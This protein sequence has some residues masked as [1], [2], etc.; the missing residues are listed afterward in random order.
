MIVWSIGL[1]INCKTCKDKSPGASYCDEDDMEYVKCEDVE[2]IGKVDG[3]FLSRSGDLFSGKCYNSEAYGEKCDDYGWGDVS[4]FTLKVAFN[5][6]IQCIFSTRLSTV[7]AKET[8]VPMTSVIKTIV[9]NLPMV[10]EGFWAVFCERFTYVYYCS[11]I[12]CVQYVK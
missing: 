1:A 6:S 8:S 10:N 2:Y 12:L 4:H 7:T 11:T 9:R 5:S 3:C